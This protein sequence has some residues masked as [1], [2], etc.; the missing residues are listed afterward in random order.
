[1]PGAV[2]ASD[3]ASTGFFSLVLAPA[4]L[5]APAVPFTTTRLS[6]LPAVL[7]AVRPRRTNNSPRRRS[8]PEEFGFVAVVLKNEQTRLLRCCGFGGLYATISKLLSQSALF[9]QSGGLS[10]RSSKALGSRHRLPS[11]SPFRLQARMPGPAS[12]GKRHR[13]DRI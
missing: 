13:S 2:F 7:I 5:D 10:R 12:T 3:A 4:G 11:I 8:R 9:S 6:K 1:L